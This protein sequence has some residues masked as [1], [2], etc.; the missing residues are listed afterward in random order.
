[1]GWSNW[2]YSMKGEIIGALLAGILLPVFLLLFW[3][4]IIN[5]EFLGF[6]YPALTF[7][8]Y[9]TGFGGNYF[10]WIFGWIFGIALSLVQYFIIGGIVGW[11]V[12]IIIK[13]VGKRKKSRQPE[14]NN[15][16]TIE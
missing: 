9:L 3:L 10:Q 12:G 13:I 5:T 7:A 2:S 14:I 16:E 11:I 8:L 1:M 4:E 15:E 6:L